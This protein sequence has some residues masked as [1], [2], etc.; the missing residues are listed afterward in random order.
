MTYIG[1]EMG[2]K[3]YKTAQKYAI[4]GGVIFAVS[5]GFLIGMIYLLRNQWANFYSSDEPTREAMLDTLPWFLLGCLL[6]DGL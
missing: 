4:M 5:A 6:L 3:R 1:A 2:R